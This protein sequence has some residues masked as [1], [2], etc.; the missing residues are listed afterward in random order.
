MR[1]LSF[2]ERR[3]IDIA[4]LG[5]LAVDLYADQIGCSLED[6]TSFSKYLGGS[7]ANIAFGTARL[8]LAS[9]MVS[10][11]GDEQNGRFLLNTLQREGCDVSQVQI[12]PQRLTGMVLL[13]IKDQDTF[14][15]LFARENCADMA[16]DADAINEDFIARCRSLLITGT[17]LSTPTVLAASR[18]ALELAGRHGVIRVLDIDYRPVL[19]GLTGRGDG[20]TRYVGSQAVTRHLQEQLGQFEL[21]IGTEEEWMIAGGVEGDLIS[22]LRRA[23]ECTQA[24]FVVKRGALGCSI[25]DGAVPTRIDDA[26]TVMGERVEVLNVLG[27]GDAFASGLLAGLLRGKDWRESAGIANACGAIVV[28]RHGCA[29][30]MPT[31][32]ELAHWFSGNRHPRP[33]HDP[34]L[35]HL[36]RASIRRKDWPE[37]YVLAYDH[38]S[39]FEDMAHKAGAEPA[40]L[41]RLKHLLN[42]VVAGIEHHEPGLRGRL[43]VL[44][45]GR[46]DLGEPALH[47]ATGRGW[48][49]GRPIEQP[50]SRPLRFDGTRSLGS[51][52]KHWPREQVVKCLVFYHP[53]DAAALRHEQ[54]EWLLQ[55]AEA[56][57]ASGHELLLEVIPPRDTLAPGDTGEAVVEAIRHFYDLGLKPEWWKVGALSA[58]QWDALD[59][60][61]RERD[62]YCRGA[63]ILGLSQPL[64]ELVASFAQAR[65]PLVKGFM[66]GRSVW[67]EPSQAWLRGEIDD[68]RFKAGVK[69]NFMRL[70]DG[71]RASRAAAPVTE[72]VLP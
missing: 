41:V 43:G 2:P 12:D 68:T 70:V 61:V 26:L 48:W 14:P 1:K 67:S 17:H 16:L 52:L 50:G 18:R 37:L 7:S 38:R 62:P 46:P 8:G 22:C 32:A 59:A 42:E 45:D 5:R 63:V 39:Q 49:V 25:I 13:G 51:Q 58:H 53:S 69:A 29:P 54:D 6:A 31:P 47:L 72:E 27:A 21:I 9:A 40:Q 35:A 10:R 66:V 4:C 57:R 60:L 19:W 64:D 28:S 30:A 3:P 23:R 71:W 20:E 15:L 55:V 65:V 11:V 24:V 34:Q 33:D 44:V 36:H 56:T